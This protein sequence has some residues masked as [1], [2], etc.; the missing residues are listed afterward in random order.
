MHRVNTCMAGLII[1]GV[2]FIIWKSGHIPT[3]HH[4]RARIHFLI[5]L[6]YG[7][8]NPNDGRMTLIEQ[9]RNW[10]MT[11]YYEIDEIYGRVFRIERTQVALSEGAFALYNY[12]RHKGTSLLLEFEDARNVYAL[13][14]VRAGLLNAKSNVSNIY[15]V[16]EIVYAYP[17]T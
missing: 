13:E 9:E 1:R 14:L 2:Q 11:T 5:M 7:A 3:V 10:R 17:T 8:L 15:Y 12:A 6:N 4:L 16:Y